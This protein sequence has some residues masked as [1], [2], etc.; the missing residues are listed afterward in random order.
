MFEEPTNVRL[1]NNAVFYREIM[2]DNEMNGVAAPTELQNARPVDD[3]RGTEE[4][5]TYERLCRGVDEDSVVSG[6]CCIACGRKLF[7]S[8][9]DLLMFV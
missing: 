8:F 2:S 1:R 3:Y 7:A 4:F 6:C 9:S 5:V